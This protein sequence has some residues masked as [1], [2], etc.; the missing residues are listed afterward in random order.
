MLLI[1]KSVK[2]P[3]VQSQSNAYDCGVFA[4][5]FAVSLLFGLRPDTVIY[6]HTLMRQHLAQMFEL[7][8]IEH[9][10]RIIRFTDP[11]ELFTLDQIQKREALANKKRKRR[12]KKA[13]QEKSVNLK[14]KNNISEMT[15]EEANKKH[16]N[17]ENYTSNFVT[18]IQENKLL[19]DDSSCIT[20]KINEHKYTGIVRD[21]L[22]LS[23]QYI[24]IILK[25]EW[26]EDIHIDYFNLLLGNYSE[27]RPRESWKI[28]CPDRIEPIFKNQEHI[29]ILH[30]C[31]DTR[32]VRK[33]RIKKSGQRIEAL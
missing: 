28:Q 1:K 29:Q 11:K 26:L 19:R 2:F 5:A 21:I 17:K 25:G 6:D 3:I 27:Y 24:Q 33:I 23:M 13:E 8:K 30:S 9:F 31:N 15:L 16:D 10:P 4:I 12:Q 22:P 20:T 32:F 14:L 7:N 18:L